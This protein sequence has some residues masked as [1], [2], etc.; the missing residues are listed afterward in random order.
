MKGG[1]AMSNE[2]GRFTADDDGWTEPLT[3]HETA[4]LLDLLSDADEA[5]RQAAAMILQ[6]RGEQPA[7]VRAAQLLR[8]ERA[9]CR[10]IAAFLLGQ[11][12]YTRGLPYR[13][14]SIPL[15]EALLNDDPCADVRASTA[16]ALGYLEARGALVKL[17]R[18]AADPAPQVR[19]AVAEALG[20]LAMPGCE[21]VL[22]QLRRDPHPE[23]VEW[24][25]TGTE[26][27]VGRQLDGVPSRDLRAIARDAGRD[28]LHRRV[29]AE[30]LAQRNGPLACDE[31]FRLA[32]EGDAELRLSA[33]FLLAAAAVW[34]GESR[35]DVVPF[36]VDMVRHEGAEHVRAAAAEGLAE[37][38]ETVLRA[39]LAEAASGPDITV[40]KGA[41]W[42]LARIN[43]AKD[44]GIGLADL[45]LADRPDG[46][47]AAV[48]GRRGPDIL[49][50]AKP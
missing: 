25:R 10:E 40:G 35:A 14:H 5:T 20:R 7:F 49:E 36:L 15:L 6:R 4:R 44:S 47:R 34:D 16:A 45:L 23:V 50:F 38:G 39:V 28:A 48:G 1:Q 24:A 42:A 2:N 27:L 43:D 22:E 17:V 41:A 9:E 46:D 18:A 33:V 12:G 30:I 29:A 11:L 3:G 37:L 32:L 19:L 13:E 31:G 26:I 21:V 8:H